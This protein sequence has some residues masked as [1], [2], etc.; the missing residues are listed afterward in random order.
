MILFHMTQKGT[1]EGWENSGSPVVGVNWA[2][3]LKSVTQGIW[4]YERP[5]MVINPHTNEKVIDI[6]IVNTM[7]H[8]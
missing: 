7:K 6:L 2:G 1:D 4:I 5:F 8:A 3:G